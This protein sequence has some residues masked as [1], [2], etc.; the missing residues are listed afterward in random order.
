MGACPFVSVVGKPTQ[1]TMF[2]SRSLERTLALW[3]E[4]ITCQ[5][6]RLSTSLPVFT[7]L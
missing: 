7:Y 1:A 3:V 5:A 6:R 4:T 2:E